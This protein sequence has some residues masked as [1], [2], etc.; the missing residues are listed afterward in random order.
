MKFDSIQYVRALAALLVVF[1]H[2]AVYLRRLRGASNL[3]D[4]VGGRPGV[5]G[6]IAFFIVSGYLMADIAPKYRPA[7]FITHRIIRIYPAYWF[8]VALTAYY[9][10]GLWHATRPNADFIPSITGMLLTSGNPIELLRLT[11]V[12]MVFPDYPLGIE[13]TLLYETTFYVIIFTVSL[14]GALKFLP[15]LALAWLAL[16]VFLSIGYP[17][18]QAGWTQP[19][20]LTVPLFSLNAAFIMG[21][22]GP[23]LIQRIYKPLWTILGGLAIVALEAFFPT[24][25]STIQISGGIFCMV[26]G[27]VAVEKNGR[28]PSN[29]ALVRLGGWSYA[30]YL[31]HVPVLIGTFKLL[32][33]ASAFL[34]F[35][36][37]LL[38]TL[39][40]SALIGTIDVAGYYF[41]KRWVDKYPKL[42]TRIAAAF[43]V[44]F[45]TFGVVG[46]YK[47]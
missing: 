11:L 45:F 2:E 12:P 47:T 35:A 10:I 27:L 6:V 13:W 1:Y 25:W 7:T 40:V 30:M 4:L 23:S 28:L 22:F 16:V 26:I 31:V 19:T 42:H 34:M 46:L 32:G 14:V 20:L 38:L 8:C 37:G 43:I 5:Y 36:M 17:E 33:Q 44:M 9:F 41:L 29:P 39:I 24:N 18:S 21:I 3:H 15:Y